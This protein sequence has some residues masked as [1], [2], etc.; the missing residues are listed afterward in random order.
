MAAAPAISSVTPVRNGEE[1]IRDAV[2]S[3][4][5]Q[6][7]EVAE[8]HIVDDGSTDGTRQIIEEMAK[9]DPRILI[10]DGPRR[11]PGPARNVALAAAK[12]DC[13]AFLDCDD[14]WPPDKLERQVARLQA[15]PEVGMVSGFVQYFDKQDDGALKPA[16][17]SRTEEVMHVHLGACMYWK[18]VFDKVGVFD[19]A[20]MYS[21]DVDLM[22]RI[23]EAKIPFSFLDTITLFYRRHGASMTTQLTGREKQDFNRA[24]TMS[25]MRRKKTGKVEP[26]KP[27][28]D[29]LGY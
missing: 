2:S 28:R 10:H 11:G 4:Q 18:S 9:Q 25:L 19:E 3:I 26:F 8:I 24:L 15:Q 17:D 20:Y 16:G 21:E 12:G 13:I 27:F 23:R 1:F 22:L 14:M 6:A 29:F 7:I 5:C